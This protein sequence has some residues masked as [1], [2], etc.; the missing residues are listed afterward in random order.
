MLIYPTLE[1]LDGKCV[2][3]T[4]G[5]LEEPTLWHVDPVETARSFAAAGAEWMHV[6]D[7]NGLRGDGDNAELIEEIIRAA[8]IPVQLGG[9]FRSRDTIE[10]WIDKGAGRVVVGTMAVRDPDLFRALAK[11]YPDQMVLAVDIYEGYVMTDGWQSRSSFSPEAYVAAFDTDPLAG[12]IVTDIDASM[13]DRDA[14]L[15][16]ITGLA[17]ATR[18]PVIARGTVRSVDDVARLTFVPNLAGMLIG[19]A[20]LARDVDLAEALEVAQAAGAPVAEFR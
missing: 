1:L 19:R 5:R 2:S 9:G 8:G 11:L 20:L 3:L 15:G 13:R 16:V 14:S 4:R 6:T 12:I 10:H 17:A 7:I 18:H